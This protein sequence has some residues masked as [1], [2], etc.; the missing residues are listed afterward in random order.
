[1]HD[2]FTLKKH[3][4]DRLQISRKKSFDINYYESYWAD[5][6]AGW[7][8]VQD[9]LNDNINEPSRVTSCWERHIWQN[10]KFIIIKKCQSSLIKKQKYSNFPAW[11]NNILLYPLKQTNRLKPGEWRNSA[12]GKMTTPGCIFTIVVY[13]K[14]NPLAWKLHF[15][16]I[17]NFINI[18][19]I[20]KQTMR[21][22]VSFFEHI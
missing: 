11:I 5:R 1:M 13:C 12:D 15:F 2:K 9:E 14:I 21:L 4:G 19:K 20:L 16:K 6:S 3:R 22:L 7:K 18:A 10:N 8:V 17:L